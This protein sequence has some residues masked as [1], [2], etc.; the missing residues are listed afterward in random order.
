MKHRNPRWTNTSVAQWKDGRRQILKKQGK[1][2]LNK[3]RIDQILLYLVESVQDSRD[4][5]S[6]IKARRGLAGFYLIIVYN[7]THTKALEI[8]PLGENS[9][10]QSF[11]CPIVEMFVAVADILAEAAADA[12]VVAIR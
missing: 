5:A 8:L 7:H 6:Y 9:S 10:T 11:G 3:Q 1:E 12:D 2:T 4:M